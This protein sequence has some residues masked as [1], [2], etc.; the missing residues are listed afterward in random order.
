VS[1]LATEKKIAYD[2]ILMANKDFLDAMLDG[3]SIRAVST[4]SYLEDSCAA[5]RILMH[6]L[7]M[8]DVMMR[9]L[10]PDTRPQYLLTQQRTG[11]PMAK[12]HGKIEKT[13]DTDIVFEHRKVAWSYLEHET[14]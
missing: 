9:A 2:D 14:I 8:V 10:D 13:V 12:F 11:V 5:G 7:H 3:N 4:R 6:G 1:V